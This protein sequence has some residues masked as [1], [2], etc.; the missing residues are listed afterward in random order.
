MP[1]ANSTHSDFI[2]RVTQ[3]V[4]ENISNENFGVSELAGKVGMSRSNLLRKIKNETGL[5]ASLFIRDVRLKRSCLLLQDGSYSV[6]EVSYHVGF[7]SPSYFIKCFREKY[8][9]P[10]GEMDKQTTSQKPVEK[11]P[12]QKKGYPVVLFSIIMVAFIA[13][14]VYHFLK[15]RKTNLN[16]TKSIAV[17]P[18]INDSNDSSNVYVVNGLMEAT[19]NKLQ[20]IKSL[21]VISRTSVEQYRNNPKS[22]TEIAREL[23]VNYLVEGS[24]Q[25]LGDDIFLNIQLIDA[26]TDNHLWAQQY[27]RNTKDIF[28][29]QT[30]IAQS[31]GEQIQA[32]ITPDESIRIEKAP[33]S[34]LEAYDLFLRGLDLLNNPT[35]ENLADAIPFFKKA[36]QHDNS[37][38]R[39]YAGIAISFYLQDEMKKEKQYADSI[40]F[41]ADQAMFYDPQLPQ[42]LIAKALFYMEHRQ[43]ELAVPYFEK[44]LELNPNSE[45]V[46]IFMVDLY[47]NHLP[48]TEKYLE[49]ALKGIGIDLVAA[50]DS[51]TASYS[52][53]HMSNA[54]LQSGFIDEAEKYIYKSLEYLPG[55]LFSEYVKAYIHYAQKNNLEQLKTDLVNTLQKD[56]TRLDVLQEVAKAYYFLGDY[57]TAAAYYKKFVAVKEMYNLNIYRAENSKI[58]VTFDKVGEKELAEKHIQAFKQ[59]ADEDPSIYKN[60]NLAL[61][62]SYRGA[63]EEAIKHFKLFAREENFHYWTLLLP[64]DPIADNLKSHPAYKSTYKLIEDNF[65]RYHKRIEKVLKAKGLL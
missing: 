57:T 20:Q 51:A 65:S 62:Y 63:K 40:N 2:Q 50:Y 24:G 60:L 56:T 53:L 15:P 29:L 17:L 59:Y 44:A 6:S 54:F 26:K 8:G 37:F 39:A 31:I 35:Q 12:F 32:V 3:I 30:D 55:N 28:A 18:F 14:V 42:S 34:N 25:K 33:T 27:R 11:T 9:Y 10:P 43:Y 58:A 41:Y 61:Y 4:E 36:I 7:G 45:V 46:L 23:N 48:N 49:Y 64:L 19:L 21:R 1:G 38:A 5:S 16:A 22:S 52:Y 13:V 47:V